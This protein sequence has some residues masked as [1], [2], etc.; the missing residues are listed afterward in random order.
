MGDLLGELSRA[1]PGSFF[2]TWPSH[3]LR[4]WAWSLGLVWLPAWRDLRLQ[5][6]KTPNPGSRHTCRPSFA[7]PLSCV[8]LGLSS[9]AVNL[10]DFKLLQQGSLTRRGHLLRT[11]KRAEEAVGQDHSYISGTPALCPGK[12]SCTK[13]ASLTRSLHSHQQTATVGKTTSSV[14]FTYTTGL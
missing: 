14:N 8:T 1:Q 5:G 2:S 3:P 4:L 10:F 13:S 11:G 6:G 7:W 9:G 12:N